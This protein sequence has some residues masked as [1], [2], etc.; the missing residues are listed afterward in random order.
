M[1]PLQPI[2]LRPTAPL[3]ERVLLPGD[4]GR[5]L[6]LAQLLIERP[7][8]FNHHRG[9]WG[10]T[11]PANADGEQLTIQST[12]MGGPSAAI[13][14]HELIEL[15][16]RRAIRTGTCGALDPSLSLG[17][18]VVAREAIVEDGTSARLS[19][20]ERT[21][22]HPGLSDLLIA[23]ARSAHA[24]TIASTDLFYESDG[25]RATTWRARGAI[26]V[27]MEASTLFAVGERAGIEVACLLAVSDVFDAYGRR[28]RIDD[29][30]LTRAAEAMGRA[31]L[32]AVPPISAGTAG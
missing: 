30:A 7:K 11:G 1:R 6:A 3:A 26:A 28:T 32:A 17:D 19:A 22:A 18:L 24:G 25:D 21:R 5:A 9:L 2:H 10:Y 8:M 12:G 16:A 23:S 20:A 27:E 14:L 29:H 31:A 15:G 13:V 4:P